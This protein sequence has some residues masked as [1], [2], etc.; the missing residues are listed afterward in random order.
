MKGSIQKGQPGL[1]CKDAVRWQQRHHQTKAVLTSSSTEPWPRRNPARWSALSLPGWGR[2]CQPCCPATAA[3]SQAG[4]IPTPTQRTVAMPPLLLRAPWCTLPE[5]SCCCSPLS[6]SPLPTRS[7]RKHSWLQGFHS[8]VQKTQWRAARNHFSQTL[9]IHLSCSA[10]GHRLCRRFLKGMSSVLVT[11]H[12]CAWLTQDKQC[13]GE[14]GKGRCDSPLHNFLS[15][16]AKS[17]V[18]NSRA[19]VAD[20]LWQA[21]VKTAVGLQL[22]NEFPGRKG[23]KMVLS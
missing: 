11:D 5:L 12:S 18:L 15:V 3:Q 19:V 16:P 13:W 1:G 6:G 20:V 10:G 14:G 9:H 2:G 17:V 8:R 4:D 22:C 23:R 7:N 21:A